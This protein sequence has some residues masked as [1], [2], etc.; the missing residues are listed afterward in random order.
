MSVKDLLMIAGVVYAGIKAYDEGYLPLTSNWE[1]RVNKR[2][3]WAA[4]K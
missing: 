4:G 3:P 2:G 1:D